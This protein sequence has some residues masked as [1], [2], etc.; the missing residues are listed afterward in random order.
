MEIYDELKEDHRVVQGMLKRLVQ[1]RDEELFA[2]L[3]N[4][5]QAHMRA[6]EKAVYRVVEQI[7]E[8][9]DIIAD[10]QEEHN[11]VRKMLRDIENERDDDEWLVKMREL[12]DALNQHIEEEEGEFFDKLHKMFSHAKANELGESFKAIRA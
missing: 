1:K 7:P 8:F 2:D 12:R 9:S 10:S 4:T 5:V 11:A 3:V 6:E